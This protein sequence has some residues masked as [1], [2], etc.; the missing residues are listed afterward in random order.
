[1]RDSE[2]KVGYHWDLPMD[3]MVMKLTFMIP[4]EIIDSLQTPVSN[5]DAYDIIKRHLITAL[6]EIGFH[7]DHG[8]ATHRYS[9]TD[10]EHQASIRL[11]RDT[12]PQRSIEHNPLRELE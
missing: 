12:D 1:M 8:P 10:S 7:V 9:P 2:L 3:A 6:E 5:A 11:A 4:G